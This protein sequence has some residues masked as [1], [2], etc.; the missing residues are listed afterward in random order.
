[1]IIN[2]E[3]PSSWPTDLVIYL[4]RHLDLFVGWE[5]GAQGKGTNVSPQKFDR[6]ICGL[7]DVLRSHSLI[8]WHCTRL[9]QDEIH[10]IT[11]SGI[12]PPD[13]QMLTARINALMK[14]RV[15]PPDI[16]KKLCAKNQ[17][18]ET[19]RVGKIWLYFFPPHNA[20][21]RGVE[22]FFRSWGGEALYNSH[23]GDPQTG[24]ILAGMIAN[25]KLANPVI[26][27][28]GRA[29]LATKPAPTGSLICANTTGIVLV[30]R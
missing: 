12:T 19:N 9:T 3:D 17:A 20:G 30:S 5:N 24:L 26:L 7:C 22:R 16:A 29:R 27:P 21:Q 15:I 11:T 10:A 18:N 1:V 2:L 6:A 13:A 14:A 4:E 23:E 25:S 28:P 8:G